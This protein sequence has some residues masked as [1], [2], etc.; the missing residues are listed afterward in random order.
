MDWI[1]V[2]KFPYDFKEGT[3]CRTKE[4]NFVLVGQINE[5]GGVNDEFT[6]EIT[7]YTESLCPHVKGI[8]E[9]AKQDFNTNA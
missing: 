2:T 4:G 7:H 9:T 6:E 1:T 8:L 5:C 3:V